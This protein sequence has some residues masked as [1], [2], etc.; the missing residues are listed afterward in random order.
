MQYL[1]ERDFGCEV[2]SFGPGRYLSEQSRNL[3]LSKQTGQGD[4]KKQPQ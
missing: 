3:N 4:G 2:A 1:G